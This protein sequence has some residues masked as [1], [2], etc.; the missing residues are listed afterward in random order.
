VTPAGGSTPRSS[1][2]RR[3][4]SRSCATRG[5]EASSGSEHHGLVSAVFRTR[6]SVN[7]SRGAAGAVGSPIRGAQPTGPVVA[8]GRTAGSSSDNVRCCASRA[9]RTPTGIGRFGPA[10]PKLDVA[11]DRDVTPAQDVEDDLGQGRGRVRRLEP[12]DLARN[13]HDHAG[14]AIEDAAVSQVP[15]DSSTRARP[16]RP[17][18]PRTAP[19]RRTIRAVARKRVACRQH[20]AIDHPADQSALGTPRDAS[21]P[22]TWLAGSAPIGSIPVSNLE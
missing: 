15:G 19:R 13:A 3:R 10:C 22:T 12:D 17:S 20:D 1:A 16:G 9:T 14:D 8:C 11:Q 2:R 7:R 5:P 21:T 6:L 4:L 18:P